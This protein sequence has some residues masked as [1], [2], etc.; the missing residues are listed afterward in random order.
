VHDLLVLI[1]LEDFQIRDHG[2]GQAQACR[3]FACKQRT[4]SLFSRPSLERLEEVFG[5]WGVGAAFPSA[6]TRFASR[7]VRATRIA[8]RA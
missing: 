5:C 6:S 2:E 8:Y 4:T 3:P 7:G 1:V